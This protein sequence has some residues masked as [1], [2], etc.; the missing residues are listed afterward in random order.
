MYEK[1]IYFKFNSVEQK[2]KKY[3]RVGHKP[4]KSRSWEGEKYRNEWV[5]CVCVLNTHPEKWLNGL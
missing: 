1:D 4:L 5:V 2:G 3:R